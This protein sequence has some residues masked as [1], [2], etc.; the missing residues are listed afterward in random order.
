ML[1]SGEHHQNNSPEKGTFRVL[2]SLGK[3]LG[4]E[5]GLRQSNFPTL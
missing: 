4:V 2:F 3:G 5:Q 1:G